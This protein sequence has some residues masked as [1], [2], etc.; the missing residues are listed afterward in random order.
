MS[1]NGATIE[2]IADLVGHRTTIVTQQVYWA[3]VPVPS[4]FQSAFR[5]T[6]SY[7]RK[8]A[9]GLRVKMAV[10]WKRRYEILSGRYIGITVISRFA[11]LPCELHKSS[12]PRET[13][14]RCHAHR[15]K[16]DQDAAGGH[17]D[18]RLSRSPA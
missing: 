12:P 14:I 3:S 4:A 6:C 5:K 2:Q 13:S 10:H 8:F 7:L 1:G 16:L 15:Q 9:T 11:R 17:R 18:G